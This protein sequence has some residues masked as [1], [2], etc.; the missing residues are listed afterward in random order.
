MSSAKDDRV[1]RGFGGLGLIDELS[2]ALTAL[3]YEEATPVQRETIPLLLAGKDLLAKAATGTGKTAAFA[4]P[5][6]QTLFQDPETPTPLAYLW[7]ASATCIDSSRVGTS[8]RPPVCRRPS[9]S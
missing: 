9:A 8:T 3:G 1:P 4:L 7:M 2:A 6:L 5:M